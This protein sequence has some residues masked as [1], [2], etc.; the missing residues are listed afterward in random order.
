VHA[1]KQL[2]DSVTLEMSFTVTLNQIN[3]LLL[4][5]SI[6]F[7]KKK[8]C[9]PHTYGGSSK[10]VLNLPFALTLNEQT[11]YKLKCLLCYEEQGHLRS[12]FYSSEA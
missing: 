1:N 11:T 3:A 6:N 4:N 8:L 12:L 7:F 2:Y 5:K 10:I 9:S